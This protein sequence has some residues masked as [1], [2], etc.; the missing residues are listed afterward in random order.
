[1]KPYAIAITLLLGSIAPAL[2]ANAD[3]PQSNVDKRDDAGNSTGNDKV[4][5]LNRG[6]LD[7]SQKPAAPAAPASAPATPSPAAPPAPK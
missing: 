5:A 2:A 6:Q 4:D 1:M 7:A 3:A